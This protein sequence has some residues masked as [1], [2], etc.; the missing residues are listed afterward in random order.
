MKSKKMFQAV[1]FEETDEAGNII[2]RIPM[3]A[4]DSDWIRAGR[5]RIKA[6]QGDTIAAAKLK[7]MEST[8]LYMIDLDLN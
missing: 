2:K 5:L 7:E 3:T 4:A 1:Y 8:Q 6:D